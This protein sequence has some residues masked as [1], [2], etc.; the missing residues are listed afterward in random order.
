MSNNVSSLTN[1]SRSGVLDDSSATSMVQRVLPALIR[2]FDETGLVQERAPYVL[3]HL[4]IDN[5]SLQKAACAAD[6]VEKLSIF[7]RDANGTTSIRLKENALFAIA[8]LSQSEDNCRM[9]VVEAG[10]V[11]FMAAALSSEEASIRE[12]ACQCFRSLSRSVKLLRSAL[13]DVDLATPLIAVR[14]KGRIFV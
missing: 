8:A 7:I 13:S 2:L 14:M 12:A 9:R 5:E 1:V 10:L 3:A 4:V 11:P 6:A